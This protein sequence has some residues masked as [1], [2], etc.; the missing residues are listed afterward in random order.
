ML[1][2]LSRCRSRV[3]FWNKTTGVIEKREIKTPD[4]LPSESNKS[5]WVHLPVYLLRISNLDVLQNGYLGNEPQT[6]KKVS[7]KNK[8]HYK[9]QKYISKMY[10]LLWTHRKDYAA[11]KLIWKNWHQQ[12][13]SFQTETVQE[14]ILQSWFQHMGLYCVWTFYTSTHAT[15][16]LC[17][18]A[19]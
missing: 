6:I 14:W 13:S 4:Y 2:C 12:R 19:V 11:S 9:T 1:G 10:L 18:S 7:G 5:T 17:F 15:G 8:H 16:T 3:V